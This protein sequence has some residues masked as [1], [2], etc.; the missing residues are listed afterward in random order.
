MEAPVGECW[1]KKLCLH[2]CLEASMLDLFPLAWR[3]VYSTL[4]WKQK[5]WEHWVANGYISVKKNKN[6]QFTCVKYP[7]E[8]ILGQ[9]HLS[10]CGEGLKEQEDVHGALNTGSHDEWDKRWIDKQA[11]DHSFLPNAIIF[12]IKIS[13]HF[14]NNLKFKRERL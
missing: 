1:I 12:P 4:L 11:W 7:N 5:V 3:D 10:E 13:I 9:D 2:P 14:L 6:L 8:S